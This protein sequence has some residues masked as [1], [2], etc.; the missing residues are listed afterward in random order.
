MALTPQQKQAVISL[1]TGMPAKEV[2]EALGVSLRSLQRWKVQPEFKAEMQRIES[3]SGGA[4]ATQIVENNVE[5]DQLAATATRAMALM[6]HALSFMEA[7]LT[8][9]DAKPS[10]RLRIAQILGK[11]NGFE[12]D[13]QC[14][15]AGLR[16][17]GLIVYQEQDGGKW[18]ILDQREGPQPLPHS[19]EI[20]S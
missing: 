4:I 13:F 18:A 12:V 20:E 14:A 17:Y 16:R 15:L 10:D 2:A 1:S 3:E 11:W 7:T 9:P 5:L 8:N 6:S 19:Y